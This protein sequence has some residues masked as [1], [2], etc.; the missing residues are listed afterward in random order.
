MIEIVAVIMIYENGAYEV[1]GGGGR[2]GHESL[3]D[4]VGNQDGCLP[5]IA[6]LIRLHVP[7]PV[8]VDMGIIK[9]TV[10]DPH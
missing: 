7:A 2:A 9:T 10:L 1:R 5:Y 3:S 6:H 4:A 8:P